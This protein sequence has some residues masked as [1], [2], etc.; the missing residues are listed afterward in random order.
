MIP[1]WQMAGLF[2]LVIM[3][4]AFAVYTSPDSY[5]HAFLAGKCSRDP[6]PAICHRFSGRRGGST[7]YRSAW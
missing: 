6:M 1:K 2:A 4:V 3:L 7:A 5:A